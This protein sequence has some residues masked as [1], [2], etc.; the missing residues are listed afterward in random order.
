MVTVKTVAEKAGVSPSTVSRVLSNPNAYVASDTRERVMKAVAELNYVPNVNARGLR[1]SLTRNIAL[2]LPDIY[3]EAFPYIIAGVEN[4]T[5]KNDYNIILC[6]THEDIEIEKYYIEKLKNNQVDGFLVCSMIPKSNAVYQLQQE[7]I[8]VVLIAR[9]LDDNIDAVVADNYTG[10]YQ[11]VKY[12]RNIGKEHIA[13]I[14]GDLE[15][16]LYQQRLN[17]Y[18]AALKDTGA[19]LNDNLIIYQNGNDKSLDMNIRQMLRNEKVDAIFATSDN[20]AILAMRSVAEEGLRIPQD[21]AVM[22]FDN[23]QMCSYMNPPLSTVAQPFEEMGSLA[24]RRLIEK[25]EKK[26]VQKSMVDVFDTEL[27]IRESTSI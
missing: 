26:E 10:A 23:I 6:V 15:L 1:K 5:R 8:P 24:A 11:A 9:N 16:P 22:G 3:N 25:I 18:K 12:L 13:I 14:S 19:E 17:G 27:M 4:Y 7:G 2:V 21:I 20:K